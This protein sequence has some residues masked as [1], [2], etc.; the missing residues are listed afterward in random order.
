[1]KCYFTKY[2]RSNSLDVECRV[3][4]YM[5]GISNGKS[6]ISAAINGPTLSQTN[7]SIDIGQ[8]ATL[9][10]LQRIYQELKVNLRV[11]EQRNT[12]MTY[13]IKLII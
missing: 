6:P 1:M 11:A 9:L 10:I 5:S 13:S 3:C 7:T 4:Q 12:I 8:Q 2:F